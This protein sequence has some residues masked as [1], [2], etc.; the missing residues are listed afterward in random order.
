MSKKKAKF[1]GKILS[2]N[3]ILVVDT[4]IAGQ[5]SNTQFKIPVSGFGYNYDISTS[6]G[7][8]ITGRTVAT[9]ITFP[10]EGIYE[11][12]ISG[13]YPQGAFS[14][15]TDAKKVTEIKNW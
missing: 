9:T 6:D 13:D 8:S 7:Q 5:T 2:P 14:S 12:E 3:L 15:T 10:A 11:I 1:F 4:S